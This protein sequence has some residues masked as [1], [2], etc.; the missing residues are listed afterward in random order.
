MRDK[1]AEDQKG[2][3]GKRGA[4]NVQDVE[5]G[6]IE[7]ASREDR[8]NDRARSHLPE[9]AE[10]APRERRAHG[11]P[12]EKADDAHR[13]ERGGDEP[14]A[15]VE[16]DVPELRRVDGERLVEPPLPR[17]RARAGTEEGAAR[18][19]EDLFFYFET[20]LPRPPH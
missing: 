12:R 16:I 11:P 9:P 20:P 17:E 6:Q 1:R 15:V 10:E 13:H 19:G 5:C 2:E 8:A 14:D 18:L 3:N 7:R 4:R